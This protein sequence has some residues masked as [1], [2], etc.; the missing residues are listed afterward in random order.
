MATLK[1]ISKFICYYCCRLRAVYNCFINLLPTAPSI[2]FLYIFHNRA[3]ALYIPKCLNYLHTRKRK[4][5]C[6]LNAGA[7]PL[8]RYNINTWK[9]LALWILYKWKWGFGDECVIVFF[10]CRHSIEWFFFDKTTK[11]DWVVVS[12]NVV[13]FY[14]FYLIFSAHR[15]WIC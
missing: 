13:S 10:K 8:V 14:E 4:M 11:L 5:V 12:T 9:L 2:S 6:L 15:S 1:P 7:G 3:A